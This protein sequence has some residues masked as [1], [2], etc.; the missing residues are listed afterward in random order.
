MINYLHLLSE[1]PI[2]VEYNIYKRTWDETIID[3]VNQ[4]GFDLVLNGQ[5]RRVTG[6]SNM[7]INPDK[8]AGKINIPVITAPI[9]RRL[10]RLYSIKIPITD[11]LPVRKLMYGVYIA[12]V[13]ETSIKLLAIENKKT[14]GQSKV[15]H[16]KSL[17]A[18]H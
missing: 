2:K 10:T 6:K 12:S 5:K 18:D 1:D 15:L 4:H 14:K 17:Q 13:Y 16:G 3:L 9:K 8:I 7:L 11:F